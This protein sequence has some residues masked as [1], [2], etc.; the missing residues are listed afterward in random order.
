MIAALNLRIDDPFTLEI[1]ER[2]NERLQ[3][4][5][6]LGHVIVYA[7]VAVAIIYFAMRYLGK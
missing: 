4:A 7:A 5:V 6:T 2:V 1:G 3:D